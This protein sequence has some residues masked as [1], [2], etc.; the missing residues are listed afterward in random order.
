MKT[1]CGG[2]GRA[3]PATSHIYTTKAN[4]ESL[5]FGDQRDDPGKD[6]DYGND[7]KYDTLGADASLLARRTA[8]LLIAGTFTWHITSHIL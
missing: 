1:R 7:C 6:Q 5:L 2:G 3:L 4:R 8:F